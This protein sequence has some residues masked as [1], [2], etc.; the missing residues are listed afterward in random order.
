LEII[1]EAVK[2]L[3]LELREHYPSIPWREISG[4]RDVLI[5]EY[6]RMD[7]ELAWAMVQDAVP[8]LARQVS[9][10]LEGLVGS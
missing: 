9:R 6:F 1:G 2:A 7:L 4:A 5:H 10:I 8:A 3:P